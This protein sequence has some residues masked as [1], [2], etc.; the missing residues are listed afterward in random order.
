MRKSILLLAFGAVC[1]FGIAQDFGLG[2][3]PAKYRAIPGV[4]EFSGRMIARPRQLSD[5]LLQ[6]KGLGEVLMR[7][8]SAKQAAIQY[9]V[10]YVEETDEYILELPFMTDENTLS[11]QLMASGNFQYVEPDWTVYP[12]AVPNDP[13][14]GSQWHL[15]KIEA[16]AAWDH[17]TGNGTIIIAITDTGVRVDHEDLAP[18][19]VSGANSASGTAVPQSAGGLVNDVH[20]HGTH[21]CGIAGAIGNNAKGVSGANWNVKIMPV[22]V[23]DVSSGG[24]S[25]AALTAG[26][27]WA[28]ENG[29][30]V[31][32]TSYSGV[33]SSAVGTTGTYLKNTCNTVYCWAAGNSNT[34][35][36]TDHADVTIVGAS[37]SADAK[38]S[39][40]NYGVGVDVFAPGV[41]IYSTYFSNA[42]S[43][44]TMSGTS[45][46]CP[47][48]AG[49][50]ALLTAANP[51]LSAQQIETILYE[52]CKDL[53]ASPGGVGNDSYW[54][55]GRINANAA[56]QRVYNLHQFPANSFTVLRGALASG[57]VAQ[58]AS[59]DDQYVNVDQTG[60]RSQ[61]IE[62]QGTT[63]NKLIG[64][65]QFVFEVK[66]TGLSQVIPWLYDY[67]QNR[68]VSFTK[69]GIGPTDQTF[70]V[71]ASPAFVQPGTGAIRA[72]LEG[73]RPSGSTSTL[74][75]DR[76]GF[77]T[78]Y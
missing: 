75:V 13:S 19:L 45:M 24:S 39:F 73:G 70:T 71:N 50:A 8:E 20:G 7:H 42:A 54:G 55:W 74:A 28:G 60:E 17:F 2:I 66:G 5:M 9:S 41:S 3:Q 21:C 33:T 26:A 16:P 58:L 69:V 25:I 10:R 59:S 72:K 77:T 49:L 35:V 43:Y 62:V 47:L 53:T 34:T 23:S 64:S 18:N 36:S 4:M 1:A 29:A 67:S 51:S 61:V 57:T 38:A 78:G 37:D 46:A 22:R 40:S 48:A 32:S 52:T 63:T 12:L 27:R 11:N 68:W 15:P 31:V 30:R 6:G 76:V 14:Y 44:T 56:L 65:F